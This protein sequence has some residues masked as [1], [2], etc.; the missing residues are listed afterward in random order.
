MPRDYI[1]VYDMPGMV[2]NSVLDQTGPFQN[3]LNVAAS[4]GGLSLAATT[5]PQSEAAQKTQP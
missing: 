5:A 4:E 2:R 3:A 1:N